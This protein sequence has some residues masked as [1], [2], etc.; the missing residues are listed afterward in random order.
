MI[1][2]FKTSDSWFQYIIHQEAYSKLLLLWMTAIEQNMFADSLIYLFLS[3]LFLAK[4]ARL[5]SIEILHFLFHLLA[6]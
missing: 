3:I 5:Y 1:N 2:W 6:F 4:Q